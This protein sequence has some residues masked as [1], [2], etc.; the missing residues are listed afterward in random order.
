[1]TDTS[2]ATVPAVARQLR[3]KRTA[4]LVIHGIGEQ[5][6]YETLD[7]FARGLA[8]YLRGTAGWNCVLK[9]NRIQHDDWVEVML[10]LHEEN[11]KQETPEKFVDLYEYYWASCTEGKISYRQVLTW[12]I[13]TDLFP[14]QHLTENLQ[15]VQTATGKNPW[16]VLFRELIRIVALYLPFLAL[17]AWLIAW[18]PGWTSGPSPA[19]VLKDA[20]IG[21][22]V[23]LI[24]LLLGTGLL[25]RAL[26]GLRRKRTGPDPYCKGE[27]VWFWGEVLLAFIIAGVG[28]AIATL[29]HVTPSTLGQTIRVLTT[30]PI[31]MPLIHFPV[32]LAAAAVL[33]GFYLV[34]VYFMTKY[35]G[36]IALYVNADQKAESYAVRCAILQ[37]STDAL[38]RI[39]KDAERDYDQVILAGHSLGSVIGYDTL[40]ELL[41]Q[42]AASPDQL[43]AIPHQLRVRPEDLGKIRG[44]VTFGSPLDKVYY[45]FRQHVGENQVVRAQILSYLHS[46]RKIASQRDYT[47]YTFEKYESNQLPHLKWLNA[48]ARMDIVSGELHFY[49]ADERKKFNYWLPVLSH[50]WY[51][52]DPNFYQFVGENLLV[53]TQPANPRERGASAG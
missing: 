32:P 36:D 14:L 46:F 20:K 50:L 26:L 48:W 29:E 38:T 13:K 1:M 12:L 42:S 52:G 2:T 21:N 18:V 37:G 23:V 47:P 39:L 4:I 19:A 31:S 22:C 34:M 53:A 27:A 11:E 24:F 43:Q 44:F 40:D 6:P 33:W 41:N 7:S 35:V 25:A 15:L 8:S 9:P 45:F 16:Y 17:L 28:W 49:N 30:T 5:N 51:W 3:A 10:R